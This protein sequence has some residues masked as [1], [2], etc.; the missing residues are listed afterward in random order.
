MMMLLAGVLMIGFGAG[1]APVQP[2][3]LR[4]LVW[5]VL[6]GGNDIEQGPDKALAIIKHL[7][8]DIVLLQ[9]SYDIDGDRP[10]LGA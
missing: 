10:L 8:P 4:V 6:H 3:G 2:D 9:E 1:P 5:N 7:E